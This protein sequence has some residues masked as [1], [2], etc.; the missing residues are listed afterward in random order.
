MRRAWIPALAFVVAMWAAGVN[1]QS[2]GQS[3]TSNGRT[4]MQGQSGTT[5]QTGTTDQTGGQ[6]Q[7]GT[8][9]PSGAT[10]KSG[11]RNA[12]S[13]PQKFVDEAAINNMA[14][15]QLSQLAVQRAQDPGVKQFA[16][17]MVDQHTQALDQLKQAASAQGLQ[18]PSDLDSKHQKMQSRL[19]NASGASFDKQYMN[20]MIAAH[21]QAERLLKKEAGTAGT[22]APASANGAAGTSGTSSSTTGTS[23]T[24][25][26]TE[27]TGTTGTSGT[28][29]SSLKAWAST[30]LPTVREHLQR[31][32]ELQKT[33]KQEGGGRK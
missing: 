13:S 6:G 14:E 16:Q 31:A 20:D 25:G 21:K 19:S 26:S 3:G 18:V 28:A 7:T 33:V 29:P 10:A 15:I 11:S 17:T 1:A 12:Q 8:A 32:E 2:A 24:S 5:G 4:G 9:T 22:Q 30:T 23:G 27:A